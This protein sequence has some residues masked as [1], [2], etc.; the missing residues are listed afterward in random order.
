[1]TLLEA[2]SKDPFL[3]NCLALKGGTALNLFLFQIPRL[4]LTST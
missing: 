4:W 3:E 1:M 2:F